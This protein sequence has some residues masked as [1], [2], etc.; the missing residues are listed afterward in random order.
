LVAVLIAVH[1]KI[2]YFY[3]NRKIP[4]NGLFTGK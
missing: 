1:T 3:E 2:L 4:V